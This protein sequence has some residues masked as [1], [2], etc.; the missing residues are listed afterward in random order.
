MGCPSPGSGNTSDGDGCLSGDLDATADGSGAVNTCTFNGLTVD[1][2][3]SG[4]EYFVLKI[5]AHK[6]W[7]GYISRVDVGWS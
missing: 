2:T 3:V 7:S 4:Q 5:T 6:N 1:G